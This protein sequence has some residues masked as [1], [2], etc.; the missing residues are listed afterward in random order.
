M[1][2]MSE[3]NEGTALRT[4]SIGVIAGLIVMAGALAGCSSSAD[5]ASEMPDAGAAY[6]DTGVA[7]AGAADEAAAQGPRSSVADR[8][9]IITGT[10]YMTVEDPIASADRA[11]GIVKNAGGRIDARSE[12]APDEHYGGSASLTMRIPSNRLDAVVDDL[13]TLGTVD[14]FSTDSYDVTTE[15]TDL[16]AQ[17]STLRASTDRIQALL[18][19]A[20]DISDI[21]T[22]ENELARRQAELQSLEAQQ[23]GL[24]DQVSMSTIDLSLTTEPVVVVDDSPETFWDG[25]VSGWN[26]LVAF[27]S[28]ALVILGVILPWAALGGLIF[29]SVIAVTRARTSRA[30]RRAPEESNHATH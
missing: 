30:G 7:D 2:S 8:S 12:T 15:V 16:E 27:L 1:S 3:N 10:M 5:S 20:E 18:L 9:V 23:R 4:R 29:L 21:I 6:G 28:G 13:R 14:Q 11:T 26:G 24:D 25:L 17:I 22:L 19:E